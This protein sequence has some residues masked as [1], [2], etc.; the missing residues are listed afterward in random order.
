[1]RRPAVVSFHHP[2]QLFFSI[3]TL[4]LWLVSHLHFV[5]ATPAPA[6]VKCFFPS[7][8]PDIKYDPNHLFGG[9]VVHS[10]LLNVTAKLIQTLFPNFWMQKRVC[11]EQIEQTVTHL[12]L[13]S[14]FLVL[15]F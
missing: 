12:L 4:L 6:I 13:Y 5:C 3:T 11:P 15:F 7:E 1:M 2:Q 14:L 10:A 8:P 9:C